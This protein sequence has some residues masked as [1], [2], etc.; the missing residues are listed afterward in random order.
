MGE[1]RQVH[2]GENFVDTPDL[3]L[4]AFRAMTWLRNPSRD[5][6]AQRIDI[7]FARGDLDFVTKIALALE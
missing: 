5:T 2:Y 1:E 3:A 7:P 4:G 6:L